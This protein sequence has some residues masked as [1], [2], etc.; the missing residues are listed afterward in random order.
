MSRFQRNLIKNGGMLDGVIW[1]QQTTSPRDL[2]FLDKL[3]HSE[4][5][6]QRLY[7]DIPLHRHT[8]YDHIED[9]VMYIK[10]DD[11]IVSSL[12][13]HPLLIYTANENHG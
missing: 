12:H 9:D 2:V 10:I 3:I 1:V 8:G 7:A 11:D 13:L 5:D 6:Y 4:P